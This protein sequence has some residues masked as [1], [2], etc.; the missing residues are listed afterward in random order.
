MS[1]S[2]LGNWWRRS[3]VIAL[4][5]VVAQPAMAEDAEALVKRGVE[6][7][8]KG[9]DREALAEFQK[10]LAI[11]E[12]PRVLAQIGLAEYALGLWLPAEE[13][14]NGALHHPSDPWI[15]RNRAALT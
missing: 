14:L 13:H 1:V 5:L 6:L 9:H 11:R 15:Q 4:A 7:R 8:K 3:P 12:T 10:A 2:K